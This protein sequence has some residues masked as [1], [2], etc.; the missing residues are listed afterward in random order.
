MNILGKILEN[1]RSELKE[2]RSRALPSPPPLR[3]LELKRG[4][5][6]PLR[7]ICEFKRRS[8]S[9]GPLSDALS[10]E[11]RVQRYEENGASA[12]SVLCDREF[13]AGGFEDLGRAY[14]ATNLPLLAKEFVI[15]EVQ[16]DLARAYG[17]SLV[18][19]IVRCLDD[20][21]L[22]ALARGARERGLVPFFEV[23]SVEELRRALDLGA[24]YIGVNA[25]DLDTLKMDAARAE[26]VLA[27]MPDSVVRAH[28]SGI[29]SAED[30]S[31]LLKG[32]ADAAL[33]GEC[34]MRQA[35]PSE[36]L[37]SFARAARG[38]VD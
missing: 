16:L 19:L 33:I 25:R 7:L 14:L 22:E 26:A 9:A 31:A 12:V 35:D 37:A 4:P 2:L 34:L 5:G 17:A 3:P 28:F 1:K 18:L 21:A 20:R 38:A 24:D 13:F 15:D 10:L 11:E 32:P 8:P 27:A 29:K 36:L 6:E 30:V 23:A